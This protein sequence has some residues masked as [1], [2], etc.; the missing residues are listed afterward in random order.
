MTAETQYTNIEIPRDRYG[1]PCVIPPEGDPKRVPYRRV[2]T[3]VKAL[4]DT[5]AFK[6]ENASHRIWYGATPRFAA[7]GQRALAGRQP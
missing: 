5:T 7:R 6:L 3:F 4:E 1:R 2:T